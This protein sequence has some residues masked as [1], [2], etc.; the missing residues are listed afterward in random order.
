L[1]EPCSPLVGREIAAVE[2]EFDTSVILYKGQ[3]CVDLHPEPQ[4]C[5]QPGDKIVVFASLD[6]LNRLHK[7]N[8]ASGA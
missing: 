3:R 8:R 6:S 2:R 1:V 4:I 7:C 5:L